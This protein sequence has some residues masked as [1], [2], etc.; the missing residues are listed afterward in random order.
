MT[1]EGKAAIDDLREGKLINGL[2]LSTIDFQPVTAYQVSLRGLDAIAQIPQP[3]K[4]GIDEYLH[5]PEGRGIFPSEMLQVREK[6]TDYSNLYT[7]RTR[8]SFCVLTNCR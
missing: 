8:P 4:D 2:K 1:Q 6:G 5:T 7:S 3:L